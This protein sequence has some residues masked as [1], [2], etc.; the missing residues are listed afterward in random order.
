M[1]WK[2]TLKKLQFKDFNDKFTPA[3]MVLYKS[4]N[5]KNLKYKS[6]DILNKIIEIDK[7]ITQEYQLP[8]GEELVEIENVVNVKQLSHLETEEKFDMIKQNILDYLRMLDGEGKGK[9]PEKKE[10]LKI[11]K[12]KQK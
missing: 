9:E 11:N 1:N 2:K 10:N 4:I 6:T 8:G 3:E 12:N 7:V 5:E